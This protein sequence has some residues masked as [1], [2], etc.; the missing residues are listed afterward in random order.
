M[1]YELYHDRKTLK[2]KVKPIS[3]TFTNLGFQD[4]PDGIVV[5]YNANYYFIGGK[6]QAH[7]KGN[8]LRSK[9]INEYQENIDILRRI[10][11]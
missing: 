2:I 11:L 7:E 3:K 8:S 1:T 10:N 5:N 4:L 6:R 9:W